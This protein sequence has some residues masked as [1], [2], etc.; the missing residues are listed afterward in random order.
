[1]EQTK[2]NDRRPPKPKVVL[3]FL[4]VINEHPPHPKWTVYPLSLKHCIFSCWIHSIRRNT[5][6]TRCT[7][8]STNLRD[9]KE[10]KQYIFH[11][12]G[13]AFNCSEGWGYLVCSRPLP[14][15][16]LFGLAHE[17]RCNPDSH[18]WPNLSVSATSAP[19]VTTE[20]PLVADAIDSD[21]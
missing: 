9:A 13:R 5:H 21:N 17:A 19:A 1:M 18:T 3:D 7:L 4:A 6:A 12:R 10:G 20:L 8:G 14:A 11:T 2:K 15:A 16:L